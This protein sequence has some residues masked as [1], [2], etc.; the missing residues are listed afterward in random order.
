MNAERLAPSWG[1]TVPEERS[2]PEEHAARLN[3]I[4]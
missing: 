4:P 1:V 2:A 3:L